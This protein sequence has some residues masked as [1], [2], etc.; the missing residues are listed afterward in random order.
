MYAREC[1]TES[2][3]DCL[4]SEFNWN[5]I[6]VRIRIRVS[7]SAHFI[8][9][10]A[11]PNDNDFPNSNRLRVEHGWTLCTGT[12]LLWTTI[13]FSFPKSGDHLRALSF[14]LIRFI[15]VV[16]ILCMARDVKS[17]QTNLPH[18]MG[19][20]RFEHA[21]DK[22]RNRNISFTQNVLGFQ[23]F[24]LIVKLLDDDAF[25]FF[26]NSLIFIRV[27]LGHMQKKHKNNSNNNN[28]YLW[29]RAFNRILFWLKVILQWCMSEMGVGRGRVCVC[30]LYWIK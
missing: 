1:N 14:I 10:N 17:S 7:E 12:H 22:E 8:N 19:R 18:R 5:R 15:V 2:V 25:V 4:S 29:A 9:I 3:M 23:W 16:F 24:H 20:F 21:A 13:F 11:I 26:C 28:E 30:G 6:R 27:G